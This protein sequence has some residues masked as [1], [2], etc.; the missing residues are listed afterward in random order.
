MSLTAVIL[1][2]NEEIHIQRCIN[3]L[4]SVCKDIFIIDSFSR[5]RTKEIAVSNGVHFFQREWTNHSDQFNW[6][7]DNLNIQTDWIIRLDADEYLTIDLQDEI[8]QRIDNISHT[9]SGIELSRKRIFLNKEIRWG[10]AE[11]KLLRIFRKGHARV[12]N[13]LMDEHIEIL[14]GK[15]ICFDHKFVDHNLH[16]IS[17]WIAKHN[18]YSDKEVIELLNLKYSFLKNRN[19]I[20]LGFEAKKKR[21]FKLRYSRLPLFFR[22]IFYFIYRYVFCLGFLDGKEGFLWHFFQGLWYR[23][24]VDLK[25]LEI[26]LTCGNDIIRIKKYL[27]EILYADLDIDV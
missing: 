1:T 12:E 3:S 27:K 10:G 9:I 15:T 16:S 17:S 13:K 25:L 20:I 14:E 5:D 26:S 6:A 2:W 4:K 7:L 21:R 22:A 18:S 24:L 8:I 19:D 23:T 11:V